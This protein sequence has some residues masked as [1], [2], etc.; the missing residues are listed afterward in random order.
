MDPRATAAGGQPSVTAHA[1]RRASQA[2]R[3]EGARGQLPRLPEVRPGLGE[4]SAAACRRGRTVLATPS[5]PTRSSAS[6]RG[7]A[8]SQW[9][10][11]RKRES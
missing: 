3:P 6:L 8:P 10:T 2:Q 5:A 4:Q 9:S 11:E 1:T 7:A